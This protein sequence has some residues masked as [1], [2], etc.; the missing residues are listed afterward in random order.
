MYSFKHLHNV[1]DVHA[2][3]L[4]TRLAGLPLALATAGTFLH[5]SKSTWSFERYLEVYEERWQV[6]PR[7]PPPTE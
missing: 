7:R 1:Q 4:A 5:K 6:D 2:R 3:K